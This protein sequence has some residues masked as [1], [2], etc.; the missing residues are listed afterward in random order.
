MHRLECISRG[1]KISD[2]RLCPGLQE[3]QS[4]EVF[5]WLARA[6]YRLDEK[7]IVSY[8]NMCVQV[9]QIV[10]PHLSIFTTRLR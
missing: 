2:S 4:L 6:L 1:W 9:I 8:E 3:D 10:T 7:W 5:S